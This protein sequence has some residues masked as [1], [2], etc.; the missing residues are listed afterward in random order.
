[1]GAPA[2][3][4]VEAVVE[5]AD[6]SRELGG[7]VL[8]V[9][10]HEHDDVALGEGQPGP[11][12]RRLAPVDPQPLDLHAGQGEGGDDVGGAVSAPVVDHD[13]LGRG[14]DRLQLR[15]ES[16]QQVGQALGLVEG[17]DHDRDLH[18]R[19]LPVGSFASHIPNGLAARFHRVSREPMPDF[20]GVLAGARGG[21]QAAWAQLYDSLAAQVL[22]YLRVRGAADPEEVLGDVFLHVARGIDEF[23]GDMTGFRSWV[24]VIAT[25]RLHDERRRLRRKP[26]EPLDGAIEEQLCGPADVEAEVEQAAAAGAAQQLLQILTPDQRAVIELRVF[27]GLASQEVAEIVGKPVGA[28]KA[29][30]RRGLGA[31]RRELEPDVPCVTDEPSLLPLPAAAVPRSLHT[32]VTKG[33]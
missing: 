10:V 31:L 30:Y 32:A 33:S 25:S 2:G 8:A 7:V 5:G 27:G 12:R 23:T 4:E 20:E 14:G 11:Q 29:L 16:L 1:M 19:T 6:H 13:H 26:T 3:D 15:H 21:D 28:V 9:G 18:A 17:G 22:G 24:F